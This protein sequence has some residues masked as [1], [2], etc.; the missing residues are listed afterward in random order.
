MLKPFR[1]SCLLAIAT[2]TGPALLLPAADYDVIIRGARVLDGTGAPWFYADVAVADGRIVS[3]GHLPVDASATTEID[4]TDRIL[5]PGFID[6]HSHAGPALATPELAGAAPLLAQGV[7]TVFINP[8]GGGPT[9]LAHQRRSLLAEHPAVNVAAFIGHN[10]VRADIL[11]LEDRDPTAAE[12]A[13][14]RDLVATGMAEGAFGLSAGPFYTPGAFSQTAEHIA[15]AQVAA[16]WDGVY[17]SH[18]R[19]EG[20]YSIGLLAA[21]DE[22]ITIAREAQLPGIVTHIKALGPRVWGLSADVIQ[23]IEDARADGVE[24]FADQYPFE[25]SSTSLDAAL[26]PAWVREGG[27]AAK[28]ARLNDVE[29]AA[30]IRGGITENLARRGG[31]H[32]IQI[33][34][35]APHPAWEGQRLDAIAAELGVDAIDA[36]LHIVKAGGASIVSFN[37]ADADIAAF[38]QQ[39]WTMTC[40][41]GALVALGDGVPHPRSYGTFP[42][43]LRRYALDGDTLTLERAVHSM[44]GLT[45][46]VMRLR[47]RGLVRP[48][49]VAD[50]VLFDPAT[51]ASRSTY[52][53]PHHLSVG[54]ELVIVNGQVAWRDGEPTD[55]RAGAWLRLNPPAAP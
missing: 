26:I 41:D 49:L 25:A 14:M 16:Q 10:S 31:A 12:L 47:D 18:I 2:L 20:D 17:T 55:V 13:A 52:Q 40:S 36:T 33:R 48:G 23:H 8:D 34:S 27:R 5:A 43:K 21:V 1:L 11:G 46:A 3:V 35:Y 22:V 9:D 37:M 7:T 39:A 24:V 51:L 53:D 30:V 28:L 6:P 50:L 44:T 4:G 19:D 32:R 45:A 38:M 15:L 29:Q 42:E 54:V